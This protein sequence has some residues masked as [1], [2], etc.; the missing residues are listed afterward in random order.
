MRAIFDARL[1]NDPFGDP[2]VYVD[3]R[4]E[5]RALLFDLGDNAVLPPRKLLR[6][7][8]V[9]VSHTHMDH[10]IG[11]DRLV[12]ICVGRHAGIRLFGPPGFVA[13]V[14]RRLGAYTWDRVD[15]YDVELV[16][17]VTEVDAAGALQSA[18][19]RTRTG[20]AR[21][22]LPAARAEDGVLVDEA[23]FRVRCAT[24]DHRTPCL[25]FAVEEKTH[26]NVWKNRLVEMGLKVG[27]WVGA[28]K[29]AALAGAADDAPVRAWW[30]ESDGVHERA[31]AF[32]DLRHALEF[33][34]GQR[35]CYVTDVVYHDAN[36]A[37]IVALA[38]DADL[39]FIESVFLDEDVGHAVQKQH[40]TARQA[41]TIARLAGAR[42]VVQFHFSPR[43]A[44]RDAE[45]RAELETALRGDAARI[46][47][48]AQ[49]LAVEPAR[50]TEVKHPAGPGQ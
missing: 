37:R 45:L 16:L 20:F 47:D 28:L 35:L 13:Q 42:S 41:G 49:G 30:R 31:L 21:E 12:R 50:L 33:V 44:E 8:H 6:L 4:F 9:F 25:G 19:F 48:A 2:G 10:F 1:V 24:L 34:R 5:R 40:L 3:F 23:S 7:T 29:A 43:Y 32:G 39:L 14:E 11:F 15:R 36:V 18:R 26:V 27:P 17:D 22:P 46:S 38:R